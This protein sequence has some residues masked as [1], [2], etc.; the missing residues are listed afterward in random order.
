MVTSWPVPAPNTTVGL[1]PQVVTVTVGGILASPS[2]KHDCRS[3]PL[4]CHCHSRLHH[5]QS[6][7]KTRLY[8]CPPELSLSQ[9]HASRPVLAPDTTVGLSS[10]VVTLTVGY[11]M[12][13]PSSRHVCCSVLL[14][15][16]C[17]SW[18]HNRMSQLQTRLLVSLSHLFATVTVGHI[19]AS[20]R[21]KLDCWSV[22]LSFRC[23]GRLHHSQSQL[24]LI[25][26]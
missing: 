17:H 24:S 4:S 8:V 10:K 23:H 3:V 5:G 9:L 14:G 21:S 25:H 16:H 7:P 22:I 11:I 18:L 19:M 13:R 2:S 15:C 20:P 12:A 1:S 6:Q 26:I